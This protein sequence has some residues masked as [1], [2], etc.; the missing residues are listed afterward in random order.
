MPELMSGIFAD[1]ELPDF[2]VRSERGARELH[3]TAVTFRAVMGYDALGWVN[4][5]VSARPDGSYRIPS[6][7]GDRDVAE[8]IELNLSYVDAEPSAFCILPACGQPTATVR[9]DFPLCTQHAEAM[10]GWDDLIG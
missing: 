10:Q 5:A 9:R 1:E 4:E 8:E 2:V 6:V 3:M 7:F